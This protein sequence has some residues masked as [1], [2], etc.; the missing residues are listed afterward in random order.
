VKT[1]SIEFPYITPY[2]HAPAVAHL[3]RER[4]RLPWRRDAHLDEARRAP[5]VFIA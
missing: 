3:H 5:R 1:T 4:L 2:R